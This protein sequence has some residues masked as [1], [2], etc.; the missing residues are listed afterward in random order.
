MGAGWN[1]GAGQV[2]LSR[3]SDRLDR[4]HLLVIQRLMAFPSRTGHLPSV[5]MLRATALVAQE[6]AGIWAL[7]CWLM[8]PAENEGVGGRSDPGARS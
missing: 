4:L 1:L 7:A 3:S 5:K 8:S 6:L 2:R